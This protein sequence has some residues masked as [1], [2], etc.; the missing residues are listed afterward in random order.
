MFAAF[1]LTLTASGQME[2]AFEVA[3]GGKLTVNA[4]RGSIDVETTES[5]QVLIEIEPRGWSLE[6]FQKEFK[7]EF[8]QS[9]N[10]VSVV[11]EPHSK[12]SKW[13]NWGRSKGYRLHAFIPVRFDIDLNTSGGGISVNDLQGEVLAKTSGG[14][15][16]FGRI[17]GPV[18]AKTSGGNIKV[19]ECVGDVEVS[20]SGGN[21][22]LGKVEGYVKASTSGG[23]IKVDGVGDTLI[24]KTSGGSIE[25]TIAE[26]PSGDCH[27]RTSGGDV[28]VRLASDLGFEIDAKTSGGRVHTDLPVTI[29]GSI[30]KNRIQ[31]KLME[32]GPSLTLRT[33][34]GN[35][36]IQQIAR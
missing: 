19:A 34:G 10:D 28:T 36:R 8:D 15:M 17:E 11:I 20:T 18:S 21:I 13:F 26:Q 25:A 30:Q 2:Q 3:P 4:S 7:V 35:I 1:T 14:S 29:Q 32:G 23:N 16:D 5:N 27:L 31:G 6:E 22:Q 12:T 9:G 33:S 24:A